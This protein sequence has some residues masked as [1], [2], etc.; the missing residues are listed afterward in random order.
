[1]ARSLPRMAI[2][3]GLLLAV[4]AS[5]V[6][7][8]AQGSDAAL[9]TELFNAGRDL[10]NGN[11]FTAAC[12]KLA[13]S[14]RLDAKVGTLA[15]LAE[16]EEKLG[17]MVPARGHW[18][19]A[20]NLA[21]VQNDDRL[22]HVQAELARVDKLVPKVNISLA[23]PAPAGLSVMIDGVDAGAASLG[24]PMPVE[25]GRHTIVVSA[26][27]KEPFSITVVTKGD[28]AVTPVPV[29]RLEDA[30][31]SSIPLV[32][33]RSGS[34]SVSGPQ[35][36]AP[37]PAPFWTAPRKAGL[38]VGAAGAAVVVVGAVFGVLAKVELDKSN[39]DG[40]MAGTPNCSGQGTSQR[41]TAFTDGTIGT[42]LLV[43][44]GVVTATGLAVLVF[45]PGTHEG[46]TP[47]A[48]ARLGPGSLTVG[49]S[50]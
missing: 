35:R 28:G 11:N 14:A 45:V 33:P 50:F 48:A 13:Q 6:P 22:A 46:D 17:Q 37:A 42:V 21:R 49:G 2:V 23:G 32:T 19:Q 40:C 44:G 31:T 38:A 1:M 16:C 7:S 26:D 5:P 12:P 20:T 15:R 25:A 8:R 41:N 3:V 47:R 18:Q 27:G 29:P 36:E 24:L 4:G 39:G 30:P 34:H 9:A 10:M 43:G